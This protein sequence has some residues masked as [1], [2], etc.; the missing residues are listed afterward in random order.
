[1][2]TTIERWLE[3]GVRTNALIPVS[4]TDKPDL[5][6]RWAGPFWPA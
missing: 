4:G 5:Y 2:F 1:M 6:H 3:P